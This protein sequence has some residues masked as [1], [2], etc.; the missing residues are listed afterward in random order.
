M[1]PVWLAS[2]LHLGAEDTADILCPNGGDPDGLLV[3]AGDVCEAHQHHLWAPILHDLSQLYD[4]VLWLFGNHEWRKVDDWGTVKV[5]LM[6][7][8]DE[9]ENVTIIPR[10]GVFHWKEHRL[11][12][13]T[14]WSSLSREAGKA[15]RRDSLDCH[16]I[17]KWTPHAWNRMHDHDLSF[18][19]RNVQQGDIVVTHHAPLL[20]GVAD[21]KYT[22]RV[23]RRWY[24]SDVLQR[25]NRKHLPKVHLF[26]HTHFRMDTVRHGT[27]IV[28]QPRGNRHERLL[29][30][31][32][33]PTQVL[34]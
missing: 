15:A 30:P 24:G 14:L 1:A 31:W 6:H 9:H 5:S 8:V 28:N 23:K 21:P 10:R 26:G 18:L 32:H 3:L 13:A 12:C 22:D 25:Y 7:F 16:D 11:V 19:L 29:W 27:R 4:H 34:E 33:G 17:P 20:N 2:D